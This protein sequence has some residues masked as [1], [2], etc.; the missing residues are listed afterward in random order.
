MNLA[1]VANAL[2]ADGLGSANSQFETHTV[3]LPGIG[4]RRLAPGTA[5]G[6]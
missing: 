3:E 1:I 5:P 6:W 2:H 4:S